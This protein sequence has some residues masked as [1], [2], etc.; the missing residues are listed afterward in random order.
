MSVLRSFA[1]RKIGVS[2]NMKNALYR[3]ATP[4]IFLMLLAACGGG[5]GG[6]TGGSSGP[7]ATA[8]GAPT[9]GAASPLDKSL[10]VSFS[11][12][13]ANGG[14]AISSYTVTC[15]A[16]SEAKTASGASGPLLVSG[17]TNN[18]AYGCSVTATNSAG[19]S[20]ASAS[21]TGT[22]AVG[23]TLEVIPVLGGVSSGVKVE[24]FRSDNGV[25]IASGV[26][27]NTGVA[28]I[29]YFSIYSGSM[30]LKVIGSSDSYY[31]D[32]RSDT[33]QPFPESEF[34]LGILP[35]SI[36]TKPASQFSV[37]TLTNAIAIA[38]GVVSTETG[39]TLSAVLTAEALNAATLK[40]MI[41]FGLD[42]TKIDLLSIPARFLVSDVGTGRKISGSESALNYGVALIAIA[43][44]APEG[45]S[46]PSFAQKL[47]VE[48]RAGVSG[49]SSLVRGYPNEFLVTARSFVAQEC[50]SRIANPPSPGAS[51]WDSAAWDVANW[52]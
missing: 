26:T 27:T 9:I 46:L 14:A 49:A 48:A 12:P 34:L 2:T 10:S 21:V 37:T 20:P 51:P 3:R 42:P 41:Y 39:V 44:I 35:E 6:G 40:A 1:V 5:G 18:T 30:V 32:E 47:S 4:L 28:E 31:Y 25:K 13:A 11:A 8:P 19:T 52:Y 17:L 22:P 29:T 15:T 36:S 50:Q 38:A 7:A 23:R 43:R 16:G 24:I 33:K 45:T